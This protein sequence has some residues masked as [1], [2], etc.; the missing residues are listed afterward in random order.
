MAVLSVLQEAS[1]YECVLPRRELDDLALRCCDSIRRD[2]TRCD[3][4]QR[5]ATQRMLI[6]GYA[7]EV[8]KMNETRVLCTPNAPS[9]QASFSAC[10]S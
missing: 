1:E 7:R 8:M 6:L 2:T 10:K 5:T 4:M 3:A 9:S